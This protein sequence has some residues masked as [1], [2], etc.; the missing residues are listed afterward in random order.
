MSDKNRRDWKLQELLE[1]EPEKYGMLAESVDTDDF[2]ER[3]ALFWGRFWGA[4][5]KSRKREDAKWI[6]LKE[7]ALFERK[8]RKNDFSNLLM[9]LEAQSPNQEILNLI[10]DLKEK[11]T[12]VIEEQN[13]NEAN[14][15]SEEEE[16]ERLT[17]AIKVYLKK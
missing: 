2:I 6:Q 5:E 1:L 9:L 7:N 4:M 11:H 13:Q 14:R 8:L 12:A 3:N 16:M 10:Q 17:A 15:E